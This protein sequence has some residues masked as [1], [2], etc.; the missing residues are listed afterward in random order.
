MGVPTL[1]I[2]AGMGGIRVVQ[3]MADFVREKGEEADYEFIAIDSSKKDL[4]EQIKSGYNIRKVELGEKGFDIE[5]MIEECPYLHDRTEP[6][7]LGALRDRVYGRF[8]LDLNISK[9]KD[10]MQSAMSYLAGKWKGE[11][12]VGKK[13]VM[14]WLV[15]TLGGGTGSGTFPDLIV[16]LHKLAKDVLEEKKIKPIIF[17]VGILP[18]ATNINDITYGNFNK[19]YIANSYGA[20]SEIEKL[21]KAESLKL[22][23]KSF[24]SGIQS[25]EEIEKRP[26]DRYFMFG[27]NEEE[28]WKLEELKSI[29]MVEEYLTSSNK[30]I[31]N[32]MYAVPEYKGG[33]ENLWL[34]EK[35]P[36]V[37]FGESELIVPIEKVKE[38][39]K[40]NDRLG[41]IVDEDIKNKLKKELDNFLKTDVE[42]L[43]ERSLEDECKAI[44]GTYKLRGLSHFIGKL[45][46]EFNK[47]TTE[48]QTLFDITIEKEWNELKQKEWAKEK[49]GEGEIGGYD[50]I[51]ELL[52]GRKSDNEKVIKSP[53]P[54]PILKKR[55]RRENE[56]I[57]HKIR[58]LKNKKNRLEKLKKLKSHIDTELCKTLRDEI[59][60]EKD[61][62]AGVVEYVRKLEIKVKRMYEDL[63]EMGGERVIKIPIEKEKAEK[64]TLIETDTDKINVA[65]MESASDFVD[66]M[67]IDREKMERIISNRLEQAGD[68]TLRLEVK[69]G[70]ESREDLFIL[71]HT[72]NGRLLEDYKGAF[73]GKKEPIFTDTFDKERYVFIKFY[74]GFNIE[75]IGEYE[76]R[77][78]E[79]KEGTLPRTTGLAE[80]RIGEIFA[81]PEWFMDDENA[82]K[83][84]KKIS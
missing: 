76:H 79:Y 31:V 62:V 84:F 37:T 39:A 28:V 64:L 51:L 50:K 46:N 57:D 78:K 55:L 13:V 2:G 1:V 65:N 20:L 36:F 72:M 56:D 70:T 6:K 26:F 69:P 3:T 41:K 30:V 53:W 82:M 22:K 14:I 83:I 10:D 12:E 17:C 40:E 49:I 59:K 66:V 16:N 32:M 45:Q 74:L 8:L 67:K 44:L 81:Y 15:H 7:G 34:D 80:E 23:M 43:N 38:V 33:V 52:N 25:E 47:K 73:S 42:Q 21:S 71:C 5:G 27:I 58:D 11:V 77:R 4:E 18:S 24:Y 29:E 68:T 61:G 63:E 9:V 54:K 35:S 48:T 60:Q 75:D 19:R